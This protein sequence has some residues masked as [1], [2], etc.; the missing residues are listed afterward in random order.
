[1]INPAASNFFSTK[2]VSSILDSLEDMQYLTDYFD[3]DCNFIE[4][5][6]DDVHLLDLLEVTLQLN[7]PVF[8][9]R[10]LFFVLCLK[11][12]D[13]VNAT[14]LK[15]LQFNSDLYKKV[16]EVSKLLQLFHF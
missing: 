14:N 16:H 15:P 12:Y 5:I 2:A 9:V 1:L 7:D 8:S 4:E 3:A 13:K 10:I 11:L 6:F